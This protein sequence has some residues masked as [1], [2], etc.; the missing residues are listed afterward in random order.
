MPK[1][2]ADIQATSGL[3]VVHR[4]PPVEQSHPPATAPISPPVEYSEPLTES[5]LPD[6]TDVSSPPVEYSELPIPTAAVEPE[7]PLDRKAGSSSPSRPLSKS[8][9]NEPPGKPP[10]KSNS[11][12]ASD[13]GAGKIT[14]S[15]PISKPVSEPLTQAD[16]ARRLGIDRSRISRVQSQPHFSQWSQERDPE[17]IAWQ[18]DPKSKR[19]YPYLAQK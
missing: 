18:F 8:K 2:I 19:F 12:K 17:G 13:R 16:L 4:E 7:E 6:R 10:G 15:E 11:S 1:A 14:K 9:K 3:P 5:G